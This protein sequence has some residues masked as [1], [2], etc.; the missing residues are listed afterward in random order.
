MIPDEFH[1]MELAKTVGDWQPEHTLM[2]SV[3]RR[4]LDL[5]RAALNERLESQARAMSM[6][7]QARH[8]K[9]GAVMSDAEKRR[10]MEAEV[11]GLHSV[12]GGTAA[13]VQ[14]A[15]ADID[16]VTASAAKQLIDSG[17]H[18]CAKEMG[19]MGKAIEAIG[20]PLG[21]QE[22]EWKAAMGD[23]PTEANRDGSKVPGL[24]KVL[25]NLESKQEK[26][27]DTVARWADEL[28]ETLRRNSELG[29]R[30]Q[31]LEEKDRLHLEWSEGLNDEV[32]WAEEGQQ[33][34]VAG[35][36]E[37][38]TAGGS[39]VKEDLSNV[40]REVTKMKEGVKRLKMIKSKQFPPSVKKG[41]IGVVEW[42]EEENG[43]VKREVETD[44][45]DGIIA[46]L[47]R[48]CGGNV[49]DR[50][51]VD[52]TSGAFEKEADGANPH[53]GAYDSGDD[54]SAK[55]AAPLG[56]QL[57]AV[58]EDNGHQL[59]AAGEMRRANEQLGAAADGLNL[60]LDALEQDNRGLSEG[61]ALRPQSEEAPGL[62]D[63]LGELIAIVGLH[64]GTRVT[65]RLSAR[66]LANV[67]VRDWSDNFTFLM[68]RCLIPVSCFVSSRP[69]ACACICVF[70]FSYSFRSSFA[71]ISFFFFNSLCFL[72]VLHSSSASRKRS[73]C[74][75]LCD[76]LSSGSACL[77]QLTASC[78]FAFP[79]STFTKRF[80]NR[81]S[82][83]RLDQHMHRSPE[84]SQHPDVSC[85]GFC[86]RWMCA[87]TG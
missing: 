55:N 45:P 30:V 33:S 65:G 59:L 64:G 53:S 72:Q 32:T 57:Q 1:F 70:S 23:L 19:R 10:A 83:V 87:S 61:K 66:G 35:L 11:P 75:F 3:T 46:H 31:Q 62:S 56:A 6:L 49:H 44:V 7:D 21:Q 82:R 54:L 9:R 36:Q 41:K 80:C 50:R 73:W 39:K 17:H 5:V 34:A 51:A 18:I 77:E 22:G 37:A 42:L 48:E 12:L 16:Q 74:V 52:V 79:Q 81:C 14:K 40:Q 13:S 60:T 8:R 58:V 71:L 29:G 63:H 69:R 67:A 85:C 68:I 24:K 27:K 26:Q 86:A 47:T 20:R 28:A 4:E 78:Y 2:N 15:V 38:I 76:G 84:P 25:G 43:P